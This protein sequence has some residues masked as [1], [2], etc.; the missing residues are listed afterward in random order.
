MTTPEETTFRNFTSQQA[1]EYNASRGNAYPAELYKNLIAYHKANGGQT[2]LALDLG[3]GPGNATRDLT[4]YFD[5]VVGL[6]GSPE[7]INAAREL[8]P[9]DLADRLSFSNVSAEKLDE[10]NGVDVGSV[11]VITVATAVSQMS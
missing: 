1:L 7:M 5:R 6:D 2:N 11:D 10:V 8:L 3:C 9:E 4:E